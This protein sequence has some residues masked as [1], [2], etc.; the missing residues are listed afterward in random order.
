MKRIFK[1]AILFLFSSTCSANVFSIQKPTWFAKFDA[2]FAWSSN[3][4]ISNPDP[5]FWDAANQGYDANLG[6]RSF[7][8]IG[9]GA[10]LNEYLNLDI[11]YTRYATFNYQQYQTGSSVTPGFSGN[12]RTRFFDLNVQ[13]VLLNLTAHPNPNQFGL[14]FYNLVIYPF[15]SLGA[16]VGINRM[17]NFHTVAYNTVA[18]SGVVSSLGKDTTQNTFAWQGS[19]GLTFA[20]VQSY[21]AA[22]IGYRYYDG[23]DFQ[24]PNQIMANSP[25][26]AGTLI[27]A[28]RWQGKLK[29]NQIFLVIRFLAT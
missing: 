6:N 8:S 4:G 11:D 16:G 10:T 17:S 15:A 14:H 7:A 19:L 28:P 1:F 20:P 23:G 22:D 26:E 5:S 9:L 21:L 12:A 29:T 2:G 24:S 25:F 27:S 18:T 13:S 3:S